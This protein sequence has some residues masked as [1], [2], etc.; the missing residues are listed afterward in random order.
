MS[1][2]SLKEV[3][4]GVS[5]R[6]DSTDCSSKGAVYDV[7]KYPT[8]YP[9]PGPYG[10]KVYPGG[11]NL[12]SNKPTESVIGPGRVNRI[13]TIEGFES[14]GKPIKR[15][16][17]N[18]SYLAQHR[19]D[20]SLGGIPDFRPQ[21]YYTDKYDGGDLSNNFQLNAP[22]V[23]NRLPGRRYNYSPMDDDP[24]KTRYYAL[25]PQAMNAKT[26]ENFRLVGGPGDFK[27]AHLLTPEMERDLE[28]AI[29]G[30]S[31]D[32]VIGHF[33]RCKSC[34]NKSGDYFCNN[35]QKVKDAIEEF[36]N[37]NGKKKTKTRMDDLFEIL[38]FVGA[39]VFLIFLLDAFVTI[40]QKRRN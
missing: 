1:Y 16:N 36:T 35:E 28:E 19:N 27:N 4:P 24:T 7:Y 30:I 17:R 31:C 29:N 6:T 38:T 18:Q 3:F 10:P 33:R 15:F 5:F 20:G 11:N 2:A 13:G 21:Y 26:V 25:E 34:R 8:D 40:G 12:M 37:G 9:P 32:S 14:D 22:I 39:G 23:S